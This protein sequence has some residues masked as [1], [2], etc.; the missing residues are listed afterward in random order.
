MNNRLLEKVEYQIVKIRIGVWRRHLAPSGAYFAEFRSHGQVFGLPLL[1]Y[2]RG[3]CPD[4]G[5][6]I[7]AKGVVAV[8]RLVDWLGVGA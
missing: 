4:T 3:I 1:H 2:T 6:R 7:V 5:R 8:G